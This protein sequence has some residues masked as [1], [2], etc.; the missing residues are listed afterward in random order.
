MLNMPTQLI[1]SRGLHLQSTER[2]ALLNE[3]LKQQHL[4]RQNV[5]LQHGLADPGEL[6]QIEPPTTDAAILYTTQRTL[7]EEPDKPE[8]KPEPKPVPKPEPKPVPKPEPV[9]E[10]KPEPMSPVPDNAKPP[11]Y[12]PYPN[13]PDYPKY[14]EPAKTTEPTKPVTS[15][16]PAFVPVIPA[17]IGR[18]AEAATGAAKAGIPWRAIIGTM[19]LI[20]AGAAIP[21]TTAYLNKTKPKPAVSTQA[22]NIQSDSLLLELRRRGMDVAPTD[23]GEQ[24]QRAFQLNPALREKLLDDVQK[25]LEK[26]GKAANGSA[27]LPM[28]RGELTDTVRRMLEEAN[29]RS[30]TSKPD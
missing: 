14:Q 22:T 15:T 10:P 27:A 7:V 29:G 2:R 21:V 4:Y 9:P 30:A 1:E 19:A 12:P 3:F 18:V 11:N 5:A 23:L 8:P 28:T 20:A 24:I 26:N 17:V 6:T 13:Y 25:T 16:T